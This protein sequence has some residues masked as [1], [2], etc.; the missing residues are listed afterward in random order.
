MQVPDEIIFDF[1]REE[2]VAE[3]SG[4]KKIVSPALYR[5]MTKFFPILKSAELCRL[6]LCPVIKL[7]YS[8]LMITKQLFIHNIFKMKKTVLI[9]T[10]LALASATGYAQTTVTDT[11]SMGAGYANNVWYSLENDEQGTPASATEWDI[12]IAA[13]TSMTS[14]MTTSIF[15]NPKVGRVYEIPG[16]DPANLA[17]EDSTGLSG[18]TPL[19][20]SDTSWAEGALNRTT[21]QGALDYGWGSYAGSPTHN[22][23]AN[24]VFLIRYNDTTFIKFHVTMLTQQNKYVLTFDNLDNSDLYADTIDVTNY[25][26]KNFAYYSFRNKAKL[27]REPAKTSWDLLFTQYQSTSEPYM[28][29]YTQTVGGVL[30]NVGVEVAQAN[31]V[32]QADFVDYASLTFSPKINTIGFD[33][34]EV[35]LSGTGNPFI[36]DDSVVYFVKDLAGSIWKLVFT[37]FDGSATASFIFDKTKLTSAG[38]TN[39]ADEAV[40]TVALYPNPAVGQ[41]VTLLYSFNATVS[42]ARVVISDMAGRAVR[43]E[44]LPVVT[45]LQQHRL[46]TTD[47]QPGVYIVNVATNKGNMQQKL[48]IR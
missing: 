8:D 27:D 28:S 38:I 47:L 13:T 23:E 15:F 1:F 31:N 42:D 5:F 33:W 4:L 16:S 48:V 22:V 41:Q 12:A 11:V 2:Y 9:F 19:Y 43:T 21:S 17:T 20:N 10:A 30:H 26:T 32:N 29:S 18:W 25:D 6:Y 39:T 3:R 46:S 37:G 36:L 44:T 14:S 34:K 35:N 40:A 7:P 24:R 45:G